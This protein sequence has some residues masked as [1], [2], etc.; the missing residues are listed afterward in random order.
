[1][2][3]RG[4]RG[5]DEDRGGWGDNS[6]GGDGWGGAGGGGG[7]WGDAANSWGENK[8][9]WD[10]KGTKKGKKN[11][12]NNKKD[13]WNEKD[14]GQV[15][16]SLPVKDFEVKYISSQSA[17]VKVQY[18]VQDTVVRASRNRYVNQRY[19]GTQPDARLCGREIP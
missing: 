16:C 17:R 12:Q 1:M 8:D 18:A 15:R 11:A 3:W 4:R 2:G 7:G 9:T 10:E 14:D 5:W 13:L 6:G 19:T